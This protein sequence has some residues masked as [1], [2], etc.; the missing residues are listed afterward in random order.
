M[1]R[2]TRFGASL[3]RV[4]APLAVVAAIAIG[5]V[6]G[7][8]QTGTTTGYRAK[9][10]G[11]LVERIKQR[12]EAPTDVIVSATD[13][14]IDRLIGRYGVRLQKRIHGGAVLQATGG[15]IDAMSQDPDA[16]HM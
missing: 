6:P 7:L 8:A 14:G 9:L 12:I 15:Q 2:D 3:R 11:D 10:S 4:V 13:A 5:A 16:S 1:L